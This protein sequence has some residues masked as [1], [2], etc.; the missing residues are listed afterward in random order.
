MTMKVIIN[1]DD[2]GINP[3]VTKAI[4]KSIE[5][6]QVTST[7]I[8]ANGDSLDEAK[9]FADLHPEISFGIH[10]CLSEYD[11]LT[12]SEVFT[13]YGITDKNGVFVKKAIMNMQNVGDDLLD[14]LYLELCA[15]AET[16][17]HKGF[18]LS[19][20]DSHHHV[21]TLPFV[22]PLFIKVLEKYEIK[23]I[24]LQAPYRFLSACRNPVGWLRHVRLNRVYMQH[25]KTTDLFSSYS[26]FA[27]KPKRT[28]IVEL[29]CHPG[30]SGQVYVKEMCLVQTKKIDELLKV[31][32]V[33]YHSV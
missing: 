14:A 12:K 2:F 15:Q 31:D 19:H 8:M 13:K 3:I 32:Y 20:A 4:E 16:L 9:R 25:F 21:H 22:Q 18:K 29:M 33:S 26:R 6:G 23:K 10:F 7:T 17:L 11:S 30:H 28:H 5:D 24:R 27:M 1:A